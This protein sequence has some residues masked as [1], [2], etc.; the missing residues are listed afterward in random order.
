MKS[1]YP[2]ELFRRVAAAGV[3]VFMGG[4]SIDYVYKRYTAKISYASEQ[5][6]LDK[7]VAAWLLQSHRQFLDSLKA[8]THR[9]EEVF[10]R[11]LFE[12]T[13]LRFPFGAKHMMACANRGSIFEVAALARMAVEQIAWARCIDDKNNAEEIKRTSA[14]K[15]IGVLAREEPYLG[16]LY[17]WLSD[18]AHWNSEAHIQAM[19]S[20][21]GKLGI[22]FAS[23]LFK[24]QGYL[25]IIIL[26]VLACN[27]LIKRRANLIER[28]AEPDSLSK[29]RLTETQAKEWMQKIDA[30][31][32][33]PDLKGLVHALAT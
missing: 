12:W 11:V 19:I 18:Y 33:H 29:L 4:K 16:R 7:E 31:Q 22:Q 17:G 28:M 30:L 32:P 20:D 9:H 3:S 10:G 25:V 1:D 5:K 26:T 13:L 6:R 8:V 15:A 27:T 23:S 2:D 21:D 24:A 14:T